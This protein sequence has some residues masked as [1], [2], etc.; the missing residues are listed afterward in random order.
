VPRPANRRVMPS[1]MKNRKALI[2]SVFLVLAFITALMA[3]VLPNFLEY[4]YL[5]GLQA[6]KP[7][8]LN[9]IR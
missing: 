8:A 5:E 6:V 1:Q 4:L 3:S 9:I 7:E 2:I